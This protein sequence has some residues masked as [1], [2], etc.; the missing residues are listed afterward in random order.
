MNKKECFILRRMGANQ[1][2]F[3]GGIYLKEE[4]QKLT[5]LSYES[6]GKMG[7]DREE[8]EQASEAKDFF[9]ITPDSE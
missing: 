3:I 1:K 2:S 4:N 5:N 6:D 8:K 7:K 9:N